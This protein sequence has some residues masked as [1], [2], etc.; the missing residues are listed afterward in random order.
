MLTP[1][2]CASTLTNP[3]MCFPF[4]HASKQC[5]HQYNNLFPFLPS[6]KLPHIDLTLILFGF[7]SPAS[8]L[9]HKSCI[10]PWLLEHRTCPMCKCDILKTLGVA[11]GAHSTCSI[12]HSTHIH[13]I[14]DMFG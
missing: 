5:S 10:E 6:V 12:L 3:E 1:V 7:L 4:S 8:H 11:V 2:L 13:T 9:F 14:V